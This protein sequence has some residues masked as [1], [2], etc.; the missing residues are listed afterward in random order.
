[1]NDKK[2]I[3]QYDFK[4]GCMLEGRIEM[5]LDDL[6]S[7]IASLRHGSDTFYEYERYERQLIDGWINLKHEIESMTRHVENAID[8]AGKVAEK[9]AEEATTKEQK[10]EQQK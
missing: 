10:D 6:R 7:I 1:M 2:R 8:V 4:Y 9:T 5:R 3:T